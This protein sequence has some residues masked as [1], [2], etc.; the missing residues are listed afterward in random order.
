M[1]EPKIVIS[2]KIIN[3]NKYANEII[4]ITNIQI[5]EPFIMSKYHLDFSRSINNKHFTS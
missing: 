5:E 2:G 1:F 4:C 3:I